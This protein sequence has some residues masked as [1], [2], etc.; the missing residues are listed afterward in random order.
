MSRI[1]T[2]LATCKTRKILSMT[3]R[4][5][6]VEAALNDVDD[7]IN[8]QRLKAALMNVL[9]DFKKYSLNE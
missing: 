2:L 5:P 7:G 4:K 6:S 1:K 8:R 9:K 3:E